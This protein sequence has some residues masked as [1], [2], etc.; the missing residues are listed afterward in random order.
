MGVPAGRDMRL[1]V[2]RGLAL[3]MIFI[4][5]VPGT[6]YEHVTSR[7]FGFSDAA[8]AFVIMS[9]I[10]AGLAYGRVLATSGFVAGLARCARRALT[11]Y[12]VHIL[13]TVLAL[14][15]SAGAARFFGVIQMIEINNVQVFFEDLT[16]ALVGMP[17]LTHQLGYHNILPLYCVLLLAAPAMI[18]LGS[19]SPAL[20]LA[21]SFAIWFVSG[22]FRL[23]LPNY[24]TSGGWFFNPFSWQLLFVFGLLTGLALK[25]G[26]RLVPVNKYLLWAAIGYLVLSIVWMRVEP[27]RTL[28]REGLHGLY[29]LGLPF[30]FVSF[31]KTYVALPRLLHALALLY[32]ISSLPVMRRFSASSAAAPLALMGRNAL[33]VFALGCVLSILGQAIEQGTEAGFFIDTQI[34]LVGL[35]LHWL[36]AFA[37]EDTGR[38][39]STIASKPDQAPPT[40]RPAL[41]RRQP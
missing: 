8:E 5:H 19:R 20:L 26:R 16:G 35:G 39:S 38:P 34:I 32:V 24:P 28:G 2:F 6:I 9:G 36:L 3:V 40:P 14:A 11:L 1:D 10:A 22:L 4:N 7:N 27:V 15:I 37:L 12:W 23:N 21:V 18:L 29:N 30:H 13:T 17:L 41:I 33:P 31:D 25:E